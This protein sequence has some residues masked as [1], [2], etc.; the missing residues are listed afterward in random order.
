MTSRSNRTALAFPVAVLVAAVALTTAAAL[1]PQNVSVLPPAAAP[2]EGQDYYTRYTLWYERGQHLTTNFA[3]GI[4]LP[5]N[6]KVTLV[7]LKKKVIEVRTESGEAIKLKWV[8]K[9]SIRGTDEIAAE[10]L[11]SQ[12]VPLDRL[13]DDLANSIRNGEIRLGMTKEQVLM[14]RGYPPT[15]ETPSTD[16]NRWRYWSS[17]FVNRTLVFEDGVLTQGRGL[18]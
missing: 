2:Q 4:L 14:A 9:H 18:R 12:P 8:K 3:R 13:S 16:A 15:H 5:I 17:R 10:F 11:G 7:A 6:S 1:K